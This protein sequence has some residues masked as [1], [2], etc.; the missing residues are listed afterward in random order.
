MQQNVFSFDFLTLPAF[1]R[2]GV[3][4]LVQIFLSMDNSKASVSLLHD[5]RRSK[6]QNRYPVKLS[7]YFD[8]E[9]KRYRTGVDL[10]EDEWNKIFKT[11]LRDDALKIKRRKL[12]NSKKKAE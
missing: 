3:Q 2:L 9:K 7:V 12:A 8:G 1:A 6:K 4:I 5:T 11:N 10:T